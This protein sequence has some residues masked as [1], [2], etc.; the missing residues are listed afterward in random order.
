MGFEIALHLKSHT[1]TQKL[2][3]FVIRRSWWLR[4]FVC[5]YSVVL[6]LFGTC[7]GIIIDKY[8]GGSQ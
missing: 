6:L 4:F 3:L 7:F 5:K 2:K 1:A 8:C